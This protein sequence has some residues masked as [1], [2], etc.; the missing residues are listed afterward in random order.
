MENKYKIYE[1]QITKKKDGILFFCL[2]NNTSYTAS[3]FIL[4][5]FLNTTYWNYNYFNYFV[6]Y[7][8]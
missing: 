2:R 6:R 1:N 4:V 7:V 8:N 5:S 3:Q